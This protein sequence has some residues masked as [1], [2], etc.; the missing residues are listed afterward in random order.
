MR[1]Q[2]VC[3]NRKTILITGAAGFIGANLVLRLLH[4]TTGSTIIG[5]DNL[6]DYYDVNLKHYGNR[7]VEPCRIRRVRGNGL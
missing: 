3:L 4:E 5:V 6:S 1:K 2:F 7:Y